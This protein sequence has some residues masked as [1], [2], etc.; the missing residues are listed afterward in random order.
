M[1]ILVESNLKSISLFFKNSLY[2]EYSTINKKENAFIL[3]FVF[4]SPFI[5]AIGAIIYIGSTNESKIQAFLQDNNCHTVYNYKAK[6]KAL[7]EKDIVL[8]HDY[9]MIDFTTNENIAYSMVSNVKKYEQKIVFRS[10]DI[11]Q[12]LYFATIEDSETFFDALKERIK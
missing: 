5:I 6:Y 7:C 1:H 11:K 2:E 12:T 8:I 9:F 10:N 4:L 3:I